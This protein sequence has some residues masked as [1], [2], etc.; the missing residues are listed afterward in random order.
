MPTTVTNDYSLIRL[1]IIERKQVRCFYRGLLRECCPHSI[2]RTNGIPRVLVYQF[3]GDSTKGLPP[4]GEW[5]CMDIPGMERISVRPGAWFTGM[6]HTKK[7][8]CVKD[9]DIDITMG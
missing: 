3:A 6:R 7:Q 4:G 1:A 9:V 2:G 8:T 5:R